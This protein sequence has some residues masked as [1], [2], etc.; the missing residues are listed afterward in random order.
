MASEH[1]VLVTGAAGGIG[2]EIVRILL[3]DLGACVVA[4]DVVIG[5]KLEQLGKKHQERV[6]VVGGDITDVRQLELLS[7]HRLEY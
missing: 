6:E 5:D 1:A 2:S 3:E 7:Q 4:T